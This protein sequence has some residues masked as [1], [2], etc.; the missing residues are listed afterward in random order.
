MTGH[1]IRTPPTRLFRVHKRRSA[2]V[3]LSVAGATLAAAV[4]GVLLAGPDGAGAAPAA[5]ADAESANQAALVAAEDRRLIEI[6]SVAAVAPLRGGTQ[7]AKPYRLTT[8]S[9][10]TL[11]LTSRSAPYTVKDLLTLAP[12]TFVRQSDGSYLLLENL[13]LNAGAK[14]TLS[15]PGG[16][17]VRMASAA[18][19]FVSIVSFGGALAFVGTQQQPVKITS[20]DPRTKQPDSTVKDGRAYIRAVGG[21]FR[22]EYLQASNLGFWSGRTGRTPAPPRVRMHTR[23]RPPGTP[24]RTPARRATPGRPSRTRPRPPATCTPSRPVTSPPRT[25]GSAPRASRSCPRRSPTR[26]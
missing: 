18:T 17:T 14:L 3:A 9:G 25:P 24:A 12:Q 7:Y 2:A 4:L 10:Y 6:R 1:G 15:N 22:S 13:Y 23:T 19:G 21:Q 8:G 26:R 20:W 5:G 11:V 16:L